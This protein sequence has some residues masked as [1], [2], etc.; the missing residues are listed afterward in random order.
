VGAR[1][2]KLRGD[3]CHKEKSEKKEDENDEERRGHG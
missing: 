2:K 3:R 1:E